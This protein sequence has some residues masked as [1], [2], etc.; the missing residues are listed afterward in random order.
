MRGEGR[1]GERSQTVK[2]RNK[3]QQTTQRRKRNYEDQEANMG[4]VRLGAGRRMGRGKEK[5]KTRKQSKKQTKR[6]TVST[7]THCFCIGN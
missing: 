4:E 2:M 6:E 1:E 5:K 7:G 3:K